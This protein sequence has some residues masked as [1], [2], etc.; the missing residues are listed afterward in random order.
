MNPTLASQKGEGFSEQEVA[1][2]S[3]DFLNRTISNFME[4]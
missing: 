1:G 2:E 4:G 3:Q